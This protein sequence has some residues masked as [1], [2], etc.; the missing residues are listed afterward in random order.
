MQCCAIWRS[1][2]TRA[3]S[4]WSRACAKLHGTQLPVAIIAGART[5]FFPEPFP[6]PALG[7][8]R[9]G[10]WP[11]AFPRLLSAEVIALALALPGQRGAGMTLAAA[12]VGAVAAG[13]MA[14][15]RSDGTVRRVHAALGAIAGAVLAVVGIWMMIEG[16]RDV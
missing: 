5:V 4:T 8:W 9:A 7:G 10:L 14:R 3:V 15:F 2:K 16:I 6:E 12:A 11:L 1:A 13:A